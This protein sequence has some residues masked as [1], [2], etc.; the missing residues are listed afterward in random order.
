MRSIRNIKSKFIVYFDIYNNIIMTTMKKT[1]WIKYI[2][3]EAVKCN[4]Q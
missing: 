3:P 1:F 2:R 4:L